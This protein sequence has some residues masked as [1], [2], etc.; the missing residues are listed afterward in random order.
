MSRRG[1]GPD[2]EVA[3]EVEAPDSQMDPALKEAAAD[4][5][6]AIETKS[7]MDLAKAIKAAYE[8]CDSSQEE[9]EPQMEG[10]GE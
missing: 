9:Q 7:V 2:V 4:I 10:Q 3:S 1:K 5:L 8:I 6:R